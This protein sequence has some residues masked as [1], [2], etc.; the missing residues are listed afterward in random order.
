[1][2]IGQSRE[3]NHLPFLMEERSVQHRRQAKQR[4]ELGFIQDRS[5]GGEDVLLHDKR[6][7]TRFSQTG[8]RREEGGWR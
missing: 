6:I 3:A 4:V 7:Y 1:M 5:R 2:Q 8:Y